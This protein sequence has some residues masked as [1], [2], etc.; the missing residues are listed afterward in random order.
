M[1]WL[2]LWIEFISILPIILLR[3]VAPKLL[4]RVIVAERSFIDFL[5]WLIVTLKWSSITRGFVGKTVVS[6]T[7][8]LCD[9]IIHVRADLDTLIARRRNSSEEHLIPI[10]LKIYDT[11]VKALKTPYVDTSRKPIRE[12]IR[13]VLKIIG[14]H[15]G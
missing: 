6:F 7:Y 10:Q 13:E 12:T 9:K 8:Y 15:Y 5:V 3:F 2:W 11:I 1:K 4:G 14:V